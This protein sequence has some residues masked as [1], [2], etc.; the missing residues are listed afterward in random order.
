MEV[1]ENLTETKSPCLTCRRVANPRACEN[2]NC[3][4]WR[5]WFI[6]RWDRIR[7]S[8]REQM[9]NAEPVPPSV[10]IGGRRY[11]TPDQVREYRARNPCESCVLP[12]DLCTTPCRMRRSWEEANGEASV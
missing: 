11:S 1:S 12:K 4:P 9:E 10:S 6:E 8:V 7:Q 3:N 2:K 5:Q